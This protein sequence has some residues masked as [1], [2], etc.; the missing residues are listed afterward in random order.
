M[1]RTL[2]E[3]DKKIVASEQEWKCKSCKKNIT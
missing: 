3:S 1:K 2:K